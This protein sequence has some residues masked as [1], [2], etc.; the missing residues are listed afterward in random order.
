MV[1]LSTVEQLE[2]IA[3]EWSKSPQVQKLLEQQAKETKENQDQIDAANFK[4]LSDQ[5]LF[6]LM[7]SP[8]TL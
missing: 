1:E 6:A 3:K 7:S 2:E 8:I 5:E 4:H